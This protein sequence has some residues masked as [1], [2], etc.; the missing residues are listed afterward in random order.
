MSLTLQLVSDS[1]I[2]HSPSLTIFA[3]SDSA[4][5]QSGQPSL[6]LLQYHF[7]PLYFPLRSLNSLPSGSNIPTLFANTSLI[8]SSSPANGDDNISLNGV[9]ITESPI[10][11]DGSLVIFGIDEFF[12]PEFQ[13]SGHIQRPGGNLGCFVKAGGEYY[14]FS[15]ATQVLRS[16]G[17]SVMASF[18]DLQ[19]VGFM[20]RPVL[21]IF[22]P[23]D[24]MMKD[25]VGNLAGNSSIFLRHVVPCKILWSDLVNFDDGVVLESYLEGFEINIT[26]S[27]DILM[28]NEVPVCFADMYQNDWLIVHGLSGMLERA[29]SQQGVTG[30]SSEFGSNSEE[31]FMDDDEF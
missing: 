17:Y 26:R 1:L 31:I 23:V 29:E 10:Y 18:L 13:V 25:H 14:S 9:N 22:A 5:F 11:D 7:S 15:K 24:E 27:G 21:T 2:P 30:S 16:R 12:D 8:V 20:D 28:L 6:S 19:L 4:F 3:P